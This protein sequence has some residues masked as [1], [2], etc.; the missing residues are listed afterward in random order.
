MK[1]PVVVEKDLSLF[2]AARL[3][4]K[5]SINSLPVINDGK[6]VGLVT[7]HDLVKHFGE[8]KKVS[9]IMNRQVVSLKEDDK[10]QSAIELV[11]EKGI[12]IFPVLNSSGKI[13]GILDSKDILKAWDNEDYLID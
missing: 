13:V 4:N 10:V 1:K 7:H 3:M 9:E 8:Q 2:D 11:R 12:G 6:I 5:Y